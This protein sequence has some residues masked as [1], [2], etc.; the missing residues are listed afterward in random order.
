[1]GSSAS[2]YPFRPYPLAHAPSMRH[3]NRYRGAAE[4]VQGKPA[5][6]PFA[7]AA[8]AVAA[9]HEQCR[10]LG[11]SGQKGLRAAALGCRLEMLNRYRDAMPA[12]TC[13]QAVRFFFG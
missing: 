2:D 7:Q 5:K 11:G 6:D 1:M 13:H 10:M 12:Q 3:Q 4:H 8:A 9:H